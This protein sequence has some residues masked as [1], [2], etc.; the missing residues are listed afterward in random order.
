MRPLEELISKEGSALGMIRKWVEDADSECRILAP[1]DRSDDALLAAQVSTDFPLGA[2]AYETGGLLVDNGWLRFLGGGHVDLPRNLADWNADRG[3]GMCLV[4]D[5]VVG[6]FFALDRGAFG[7]SSDMFYWAPDSL[8]WE[9]IGFEF[10]MFLQWSMTAALK[11]FY[12]HFRWSSWSSDV[13]YAL[14]TDHCFVF[15]PP[16]WEKRGS[17]GKSDRRTIPVA[18]LYDLKLAAQKA[19]T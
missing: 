3:E 18:E 17:V 7:D 11:D 15:D 9:P 14:A 12:Q 13:N 4:A 8:R 16:L 10:D 5:D 2:L 6:G 1:M 19:S